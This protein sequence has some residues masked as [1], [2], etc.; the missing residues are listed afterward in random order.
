MGWQTDDG[1]HE[2]TATAVFPDGRV[3]VG[4]V[5]GPL[6]QGGGTM[7]RPVRADGGIDYAAPTAIVDGRTAIGWRAWCECGW[8]GPL[9]QRVATAA[10]HDFAG[11]RIYDG[12][13]VDARIWGDAPQDVE[14]A[15]W[16]EWREHVRPLGALEAVR[17]QAAEVAAAQARL[18]EAVRA[19]RKDGCSWADIGTA[20]GITR[21]SAHER[22]ARACQE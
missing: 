2:G 12:E 8:R 20:A 3:S 5:G 13:F 11:R 10:D 15:I 7:V 17:A 9:W 1:K 4:S 21:Q 6:D 19:A 16:A 18:T 22:W 14:E